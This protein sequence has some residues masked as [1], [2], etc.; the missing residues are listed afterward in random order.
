MFAFHL[1]FL[2]FQPGISIGQSFDINK[3]S[4]SVVQVSTP[5]SA[6][7]GSINFQDDN[8]FVLTNRHVVEGHNEFLISVLFDV[9]EPAEPAYIADLFSFSPDYDV[10]LLRIISD[11]NGNEVTP[12]DLKCEGDNSKDCI[13][14]LL[15]EDDLYSIARGDEVALFSYPGIG[16]NEL[17]Y[18]EGIISSIKYDE[19]KGERMPIWLR[20]NADMAPG[21]SGGLAI[22]NAGKVVGVPTYVRTEAQTG[23]RLGNILSAQVIFA[24]LNSENVLFSWEDFSDYYLPL[25]FSFEP[26]YG[27]VD[28]TAGFLPHPYTVNM[29]AGGSQNVSYLGSECIG[30]ASSKPDYR[31]NW[32]GNSEI[33]YIFFIASNEEEDAT[34]IVRAPDGSW[35]CND[36]AFEGTL[37]PGVLFNN[38]QNGQ[39]NIWVGSYYENE[40][41]SGTLVFSEGVDDSYD[42]NTATQLDWN[43]EPVYGEKHLSSGFLP[44]P[45]RVKVMSGGPINVTSTYIGNGCIGYVSQAP[46]F[47]LHWSGSSSSLNFFFVTTNPRDDT[48]LIINAPNGSWH[49]NDDAH[50]NTFNPLIKFLNPREGQYDIWIG[51]YQ[52]GEYFN[53]ELVISE[54]D[55]KVP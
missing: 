44:D 24:S 39:Y 34:I 23:S 55:D 49:C 33:L 1:M 22:N 4:R 12:N 36:D 46:D 43:L 28:L 35:H 26:I 16:E 6:G 40:Y 14:Q 29:V 50:R 10:A 15:F 5:T 7:S 38:P 51:S 37:D 25:D 17:V 21:S 20:T 19:Y 52:E 18:S 9:N 41:I 27:D 13:S 2:I 30:F 45:V 3:I 32:S 8:I 53:G 48:T 42:E 31:L 47:R 11:I 54:I